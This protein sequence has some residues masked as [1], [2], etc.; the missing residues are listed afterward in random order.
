MNIGPKETIVRIEGQ[1]ALVH[2]SSVIETTEGELLCVWYQGAYETASDTV[3]KGAW[4]SAA[5]AW[6][7]PEV[8]FDFHGLALGNPVLWRTPDGL[9]NLTF[10]ALLSATWKESLLFC[11]SSADGG[12]TWSRPALFTPRIGMMA[13]TRPIT[14][15]KGQIIFPLYSEVEQCPYIWV[16][17][18]PGDYLSGSFVAETMARGKAIQPAL[19]RLDDGRMLML[20]RTNQE[21][22]WQSH[23]CNEGYTWSIL[24]PVEIPNPDSAIDLLRLSS[25]RLLL[26]GNDSSS[27][28][29]RLVA[30]SSDDEGESWSS[31]EE[32]ASGDGEYSYPSA[33]LR[34]DGSVS[35]TFTGGRYTIVHVQIKE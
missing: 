30:M 20:C 16:L 33:V 2:C 18:D 7:E 11:A 32:I 23:S 1:P 21:R 26:V 4:R 3:L 9:L 10:S 12:R 34:T 25:G 17:E 8:L 27:D 19:C 29:K 15:S 13:K 5:G 28:R 31:P 24:R 22:L 6:S 14:G 35:V